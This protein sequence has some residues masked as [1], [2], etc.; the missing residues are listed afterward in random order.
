[1]DTPRD[2]SDLT[3]PLTESSGFV[4]V[5]GGRIEVVDEDG[6]LQVGTDRLL[7]GRSRRCHL[8]LDD[9]TVS[10]VHVEVQA[11]PQ[12]VRVVDQKSRNGSFFNDGRSP[13]GT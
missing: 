9:T 7:I 12:G 11:T 5:R 3:R 8:V 4:S 13:N 10:A 6:R 2:P 1:M